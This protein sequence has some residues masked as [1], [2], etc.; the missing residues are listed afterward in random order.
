MAECERTRVPESG[1]RSG[2]V[3]EKKLS[4]KNSPLGKSAFKP[5]YLERTGGG[6]RL[7]LLRRAVL[8]PENKRVDKRG[9]GG[10]GAA[11]VQP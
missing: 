4:E 5:V 9:S 2:L 10:G 3:K 6:D 8:K 7:L 1:L 11:S